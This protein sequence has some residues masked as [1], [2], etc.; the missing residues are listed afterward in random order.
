MRSCK[1]CSRTP[2]VLVARC[3]CAPLVWT[4][5]RKILSQR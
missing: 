5:I 2:S 3:I 1:S 4:W